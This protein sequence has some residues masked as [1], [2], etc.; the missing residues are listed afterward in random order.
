[1]KAS[2]A[3][4]DLAAGQNAPLEQLVSVMLSDAGMGKATVTW[5]QYAQPWLRWCNFCVA[6]GF[7]AYCGN[8]T[9]TAAFLTQERIAAAERGVGPQAVTKASAAISAHYA[10]LGLPS[11]CD[12][13]SVAIAR[14]VA[15]RTLT[16]TKL[17]R[18]AV[19]TADVR[20]LVD[21]HLRPGCLLRVRMVVTCLVL[22]YAGQ[23]R[24]DDLSHVMVHHDLMRFFPDRVELYLWRAKNDQYAV[25]AWVTI[26]AVGGPY[27][28][29]GLLHALLSAGG[30]KTSPAEVLTSDGSF[31]D[32]EDV[33]PLLRAVK[34]VAGQQVLS[35]V[36]SPL[37]A[38]IP[39]LSYSSFTALL[40]A[41]VREAGL[42]S[43]ILSHSFRIGAS[44]T[45]VNAG[46]E[47]RLVQNAGR[48][49]SSQ[50][51]FGSY[52]RDS[53]AAKSSVSLSLGLGLAPC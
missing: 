8:Q 53:V 1:M 47:P 3:A 17:V 25:G 36:A 41:L 22:A 35:Q 13:P 23:L 18:T 29:V 34:S 42:P 4:L 28:P 10:K 24:F 40:K 19:S 43:S 27:C 15:K 48:W 38:F 12:G 2:L 50:V 9:L 5:Q 7:G 33:G 31:R 32:A 51:F 26:A 30:Y 11:P 6:H 16:G 21:F 52:V 39:A 20:A 45:A 37:Q 44:S 49:R 46:V 14:E